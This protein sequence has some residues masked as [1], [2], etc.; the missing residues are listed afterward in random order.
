MRTLFSS[1]LLLLL[2][3]LSSLNLFAAEQ[4]L[5]DFAQIFSAEVVALDAKR[6]RLKWHMKDDSFLF[7][8]KFRLQSDTP[9]ISFGDLE[10]PP[11]TPR[12]DAFL[13]DFS[14]YTQEIELKVPVQR[15]ANGGDTLNFTVLLQGCLD[16]DHCYPQR[17]ESFSVSLP[18]QRNEAT[19]SATQALVADEKT[20]AETAPAANAEENFLDPEVAFLF[21][22]RLS[23]DERSLHASWQIAEG[24]YLYRDKIHFSADQHPDALGVVQLPSGQIKQ[25]EFFGKV[26]IYH[27]TLN[28]D[29]PLQNVQGLENL[30]VQISYQGCAEAGLCYPPQHKNQILSLT[31]TSTNESL[32]AL[33][34]KAK[35]P[36]A[37]L[38]DNSGANL[39]NAEDFLDPEMAF[40]FSAEMDGNDTLVAHWQITEGYYLYRHKFHF[41]LAQGT[42]GEAELPEGEVKQDEYFGRVE[43]YHYQVTARLPISD[44]QGLDSLKLS[45]KY[46]GCADAGLCYPPQ[47]KTLSV[48]VTDANVRAAAPA[49]KSQAAEAK[50]NLS[51]QDL[52][53]QSLASDNLLW[54]LLSFF[55]FGLLLA[56]TPCVFPMIPILSSIVVG[57]GAALTTRKAFFMSLTYVLAMAF[58]YA[59]AGAL[60]GVLGENIQA[61]FQNPWVLWAFALVFVALALSMFGF[62][63]LQLPSSLQSKLTEISN[64]QSGGTLI[65]VAIMGFLSALIVGPCVAAPL[66]GA[67]IYISQT[68]NALLGF[69]ALFFMSL[70]MGV[71]LLIIGTSAGK[72]LPRA[73]GWMDTVKHVFGV[74]LLATGVWMLDRVI[75]P[76]ATLL[77][78]ALLLIVP[79]IYMGALDNLGAAA[80]GWQKFWKGIA[81]VLLVYGVLLIIGAASGGSSLLQ[82][83]Q[84][85]TVGSGKGGGASATAGGLN[86]QRIKGL[87]GLQQALEQAKA[88]HQPVMLDFYADWCVSCVEMEHNTFSDAQVQQALANS[89]LLQTDVTQNDAQ[90]KA[91]LKHFGLFG[92]PA[93]LFYTAD[94][95]E[96]KAKRLVGFKPA[97]AFLAHVQALD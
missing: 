89:L 65:G 70:G 66:A 54:I 27:G 38:Q 67:L 83:L 3:W 93:I 81:V 92:P 51:E 61:A 35:N 56:L 52:I 33:L 22:S 2:G 85:L 76:Q 39:H 64:Q 69:M 84:G 78:A 77:L 60:A 10:L 79:A 58:T 74:L 11:A 40:Q 71:P 24:Y 26:E 19:P 53:A 73:G 16:L 63:Q 43:A 44:I 80:S 59:L 6:L 97:K 46:Q 32:A 42:L 95:E 49:A 94:G 21:S 12:H 45:V 55:G 57:Q 68:G 36:L 90:D 88:A 34:N 17:A 4:T 50:D 82:P 37:N 1:P 62:Y 8:N 72:L 75:P 9:G 47:E 13:G 18:P 87:E 29:V 48:P 5:P 23:D 91:L 86:F 41:A 14:V 7:A 15:E 20:A 96:L 28:I 30:G 31:P 25:D